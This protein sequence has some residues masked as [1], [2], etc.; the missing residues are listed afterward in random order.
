LPR[1]L[2]HEAE[3]RGQVD[4]ILGIPEE[5][6]AVAHVRPSVCAR[7]GDP[8][9]VSQALDEHPELLHRDHQLPPVFAEER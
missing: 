3:L 8:E 2:G 6:A 4:G 5:L 7:V 9:A 1:D